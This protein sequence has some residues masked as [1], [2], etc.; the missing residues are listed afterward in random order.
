MGSASS[1][2]S[3][4]EA[5][6]LCS[7]SGTVGFVTVWAVVSLYR[8]LPRFVCSLGCLFADTTW[9]WVSLNHQERR[10][11]RRL[12][13]RLERMVAQQRLRSTVAFGVVGG[14]SA[15]VSSRCPIAEMPASNFTVGASGVPALPRCLAGSSFLVM[16]AGTFDLLPARSTLL[17]RA[18]G[19]PWVW[20]RIRSSSLW[21]DVAFPAG[22]SSFTFESRLLVKR[23]VFAVFP[24]PSCSSPRCFVGS[25]ALAALSACCTCRPLA[26]G[27]LP[28]DSSFVWRPKPLHHF[29]RLVHGP[30]GQRSPLRR[31]VPVSQHMGCLFGL[32]EACFLL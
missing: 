22:L 25:G 10:E 30:L 23:C 28:L 20:H 7:I 4:C 1:S 16:F 12:P 5:K 6:P 31:L 32:L 14:S 21:L 9:L 27:P 11:W 2:S 24:Q 13:I 26:L 3:A 15:F 8:L 17:S 29:H 18:A 19:P